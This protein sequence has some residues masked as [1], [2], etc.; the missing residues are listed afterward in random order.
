M[1][2]VRA[3]LWSRPGDREPPP[4]EAQSRWR[5]APSLHPAY[6]GRRASWLEIFYDVVVAGTMMAASKALADGS[7]VGTYMPFVLQLAAV[8]FA[9]NAFTFYQIGGRFGRSS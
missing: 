4:Q 2:P 1:P 6:A 9:W 8:F 3:R 5:H 7:A